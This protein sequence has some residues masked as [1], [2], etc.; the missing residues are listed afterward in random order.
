MDNYGLFPKKGKNKNTYTNAQIYKSNNNTIQYNTIQNNTIQNNTKQYKTNKTKQNKTEITMKQQIFYSFASLVLSTYVDAGAIGCSPEMTC[1][2]NNRICGYDTSNKDKAKMSCYNQNESRVFSC[3]G[4]QSEQSCSNAFDFWKKLNSEF[5]MSDGEVIAPEFLRNFTIPMPIWDKIHHVNSRLEDTLSPTCIDYINNVDRKLASL[6]LE[7]TWGVYISSGELNGY[8]VDKDDAIEWAE[9]QQHNKINRF[10]F[11]LSNIDWR[12]DWAYSSGY[13]VNQ[14]RF[15]KQV[16]KH[17][18][19]DCMVAVDTLHNFLFYLKENHNTAY[20]ALVNKVK[21][22]NEENLS[23]NKVHGVPKWLKITDFVGLYIDMIPVIIYILPEISFVAVD[24]VAVDAAGEVA[25]EAG[26]DVAA[27]SGIDASDIPTTDGGE[28]INGG[29]GRI[30]NQLNVVVPYDL[31]TD[32]S[33]L[34]NGG[35]IQF[36]A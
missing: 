10:K 2:D 31:P 27:D 11:Y 4:F 21:T 17:V 25:A 20:V 16:L 7:G 3:E 26:S 35:V 33:D 14:D 13:K 18:G 1:G 5:Y 34:V 8:P 32:F 9:K 24:T 15:W 6:E 36:D 12:S 29:D 22:L 28:I 30:F 19:T 23:N